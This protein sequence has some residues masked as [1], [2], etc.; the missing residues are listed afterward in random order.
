[1]YNIFSFHLKFISN[2]YHINIK[3]VQDDN[4]LHWK[5]YEYLKIKMGVSLNQT[6]KRKH[7]LRFWFQQL[8]MILFPTSQLAVTVHMVKTASTIAADTASKMKLVTDLRDIVLMAVTLVGMGKRVTEVRENMIWINDKS[9]GFLII[10]NYS[11]YLH[12]QSLIPSISCG[13]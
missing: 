2:I 6:G 5:K 9:I 1:M 8:L 13:N 3:H 7:K 11:I 12:P 10:K 4:I